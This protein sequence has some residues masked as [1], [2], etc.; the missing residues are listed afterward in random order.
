MSIKV[1]PQPHF[2]VDTEAERDA[3]WPDGSRMFCND[4]KKTYTLIDNVFI[5]I[6]EAHEE[7]QDP[8]DQYNVFSGPRND[9]TINRDV[10]GQITSIETGTTKKEI[11]RDQNGYIESII[12]NEGLKTIT[13][14]RDV[15]NVMIGWT[16]S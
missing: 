11:T 14:V 4:T 2:I 7:A 13:I 1:Q 12:V 5:A 6:E 16:I 10:N 3:N 8:H 15:N 9:G